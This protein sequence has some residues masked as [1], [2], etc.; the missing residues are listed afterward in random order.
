[1][2][3]TRVSTEGSDLRLSSRVSKPV[4]I[5]ELTL[6]DQLYS[7]ELAHKVNNMD[8]NIEL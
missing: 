7:N 4:D 3:D 6:E 1:M 2:S 8:G 5:L